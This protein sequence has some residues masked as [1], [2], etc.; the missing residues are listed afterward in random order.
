MSVTQKGQA[1]IPKALRDK[2]RVKGKVHTV[3]TSEGILLK[4]LPRPEDDFGSLKQQFKGETARKNLEESRSKNAL[5]EK[6]LLERIR[7]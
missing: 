7:D 4:P 3:E 5:R 2:F 6:R 1:T